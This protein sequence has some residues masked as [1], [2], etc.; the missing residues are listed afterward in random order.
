MKIDQ[1]EVLFVPWDLTLIEDVKKR[2]PALADFF[3]SFVSAKDRMVLEVFFEVKRAKKNI[4]GL[5]FSA[6]SN[7]KVTR[8][9]KNDGIDCIALE[10]NITLAP[11][12]IGRKDETRAVPQKVA[13]FEQLSLDDA[14]PWK[15]GRL[16]GSVFLRENAWGKTAF[17]NDAS[18]QICDIS[19]RQ[20]DTASIFH[21]FCL[22][23][24]VQR[25]TGLVVNSKG[26]LP[27]ERHIGCNKGHQDLLAFKFG[28]GL[29]NVYPAS[30]DLALE[31]GA[32]HG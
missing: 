26:Q 16:H 6:G 4:R 21:V 10:D 5:T 31:G 18:G 3:P 19:L 29:L 1:D 8:L 14:K 11:R 15:F 22:G 25:R 2:A 7:G 20:S 30:L 28:Q 24:G 13:L 17:R 23:G 32:V 9:R 12:S 27:R